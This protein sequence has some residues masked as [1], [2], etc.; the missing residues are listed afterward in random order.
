MIREPMTQIEHAPLEGRAARALEYA[1]AVIAIV[2][3]GILSLAR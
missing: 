2:A 3:A 1:I